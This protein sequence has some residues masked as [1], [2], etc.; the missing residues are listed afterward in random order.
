MI[1]DVC[2]LIL[3]LS[4]AGEVPSQLLPVVRQS[5]LLLEVE[6]LTPSDVNSRLWSL[7]QAGQGS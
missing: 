5:P 7:S 4:G 3:S 2:W 1:S 6:T